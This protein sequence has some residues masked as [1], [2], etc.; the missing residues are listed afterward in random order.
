MDNKMEKKE[1][2]LLEY[3][4]IILKRKW[5]I[6]SFVASLL[7]FVGI[8]SFTST[9]LYVA[10][11][12]ILI[13]DS[14]SSLLNIQ[15]IS[16]YG[17]YR[18]DFLGTYFK[19]QLKLL[20]SR[21]LAERVAKKMNLGSRQELQ[22]PHFSRGNLFQTARHFFSFGWMFPK[23]KEAP[24]EKQPIDQ[25]DS[26]SVLA[27]AVLG[28]LKITPL[29]ETRLVE[30][31]YTS[32]YPALAADIVN[33]LV[34]EFINY[35]VE[36]RYEATQ[37]ASEFLSE[38]IAQLREDLGA[39]EKELQKYGE[40][41]KLLL[42]N[43]KE[44]TVVSKFAELDTAFTEA[45]IERVNK[46]AIFRELQGLDIDSAPQYV[47]NS[48]IQSLKTSYTQIKSEYE[49][50]SKIFKPSY[51]EMIKLR[52]RLD[53]MKAE[54]EN[55]IKK[56]VDAAESEFRTALKKEASLR[57]LLESQRIDVVRMNN[58]AILYNSLKI[59]V[60]N[61]RSLLNSL[62]GKQN[63]TLVSARLGGLRT[64]NI[65]IVDK[66]LVPN[67]PFSP[68]TRR[69]LIMALLLGLFG[70]LG[71]AF[72]VEY[73]D[74]SVKGPE[75]V[76]KITGLPSLGIIPQFTL[77]GLKKRYG[78]SSEYGYSY[79]EGASGKEVSMAGVKEIE[80][81]NHFLPKFSIS[82]DYRTVRTSILFSHAEGVPKT[83]TFTSTLPQE[84]KTATIS[85]TAVAF[86]QLGERVLMID[87]DLRR[88]RLHRVFKVRNVMGLSS[89]LTGKASLED[90][91]QVTSIEN[92]WLIPSG[93]H[94]PNPAE[95]LNSERMKELMRLVKEN[96]DIVLIDTPPVLAAIDPVIIS[97]LSDCTVFVVRAGKT[98]RKLFLQAV[99]EIRKA[100]S[101]I[102]GVIFNEVTIKKDKY[103]SPYY[104]YYQKEYYGEYDEQYER[105][106]QES[107][108]K[109]ERKIPSL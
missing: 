54:L 99:E 76:E 16:T 35:S 29:V 1:I 77:N 39:K 47:N 52:A 44:S 22:S 100:K 14:S 5:I 42:L 92:I 79:G 107:L 98:G 59:E 81:I 95:L 31:G 86:A 32:P 20:G 102:I 69:H 89:Y 15:D 25:P 50:K 18:Y 61:K 84:G 53:S 21:S 58:N 12:S 83:I 101:Q 80:L 106:G 105:R 33:T 68:N 27:Y 17:E 40:E 23:K 28:G 55:E 8:F 3:W 66:A 30:I 51:P 109:G 9:P 37:Q 103:Y 62:V 45:Q 24:D 87:G 75:D 94:P 38:Q 11:A 56:A 34:E 93:L 41:K 67:E 96:F 97:S 88:H 82:E 85:N 48:L 4:R 60:E 10:S 64:S 6:V 78:Y 7:A 108:R 63:E 70:G 46:E 90:V 104:H 36:T 26:Y 49:E 2:D 57:H 71:L 73:L 74:N 91:I 72:L 43:E 19:T 13:E 65:K